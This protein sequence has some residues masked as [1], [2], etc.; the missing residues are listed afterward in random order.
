MHGDDLIERYLMELDAELR[1]PRRARRRIVAEARDH[2][3]ALMAGE[4]AERSRAAE[5]QA[6]DDFGAP[7]ALARGFHHELAIGA[8]RRAAR[9]GAIM[10]VLFL[11]LCDL[12][13]SS[14]ISVPLGWATDGP[15][16]LLIWIIGQVGLVAGVVSF[17][18]VH[19]ARR[20]DVADTVRLRYAVKGL[21]V[22]AV[23]AAIAVTIAASGAATEL[24]GTA[25]RQSLIWPAALVLVCAAMTATGASAAWRA[26][27]RLAA[28]ED[29][30]LSASGREAAT[31]LLSAA[32]DGLA[33]AAH[34][35]RLRTSMRPPATGSMVPVA[36]RALRPFDPQEHP[37]RYGTLVALLAGSCVPLL[38]LAV[39]II[40]GQLNGAQ[41]LDLAMIAPALIAFEAALAL[42]GYALLGRFLGLR[43][44]RTP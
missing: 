23:C 1:L 10:F 43:P 32:G 9:C 15:G 44:T 38:A 7:A 27:R 26:R 16:T 11:V 35:L 14:F 19:N 29:T 28:F 34:H 3:H 37:W 6:I 4:G 24:T 30:P 22:L 18:R 5:S 12:C 41:L 21:I 39:L 13:T 20:L 25:A 8:T 40:K 33:W 2:L 31:D 42:S 17:A 36:T